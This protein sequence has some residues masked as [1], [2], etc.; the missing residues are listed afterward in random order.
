MVGVEEG[1][2][3]RFRGNLYSQESTFPPVVTVY[4]SWPEFAHAISGLHEILNSCSK[5][6]SDD[7]LSLSHNQLRATSLIGRN[8]VTW[9]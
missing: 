3:F 8:V 6:H 2:E 4:S 5:R 1:R 7:H 9:R